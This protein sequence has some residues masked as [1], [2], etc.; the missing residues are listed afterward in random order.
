MTNHCFNDINVDRLCYLITNCIINIYNN[1]ESHKIIKI[2]LGFIF[3]FYSLF[4]NNL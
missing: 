2:L 3:H 1:N 4:L